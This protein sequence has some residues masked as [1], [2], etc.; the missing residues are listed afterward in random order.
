[1][2]KPGKEVVPI[3]KRRYNKQRI[4][5]I[6]VEGFFEILDWL[7]LTL[8]YACLFWRKYFSLPGV[9]L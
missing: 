4:Q 2:Q 1:M 6:L 5:Q 9:Y 8:Y 3:G 7:L